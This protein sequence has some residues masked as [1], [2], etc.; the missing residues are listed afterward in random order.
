MRKQ[1]LAGSLV[2]GVGLARALG[3]A[4]TAV[5]LTYNLPDEDIIVAHRADGSGT[6][7]IFVDYLSE[8]QRMASELNYAPL[9]EPVVAPVRERL[10]S[11]RAALAFPHLQRLE[12]PW[13][14]ALFP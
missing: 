12:Q 8:A 10:Q 14:H 3:L 7:Y 9:P 4:G 1:L 13:R 6:T 5:V 11:L 2:S